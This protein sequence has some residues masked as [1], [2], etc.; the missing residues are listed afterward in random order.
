MKYGEGK[1]GNRQLR[2]EIVPFLEGREEE[3]MEKMRERPNL[4]RVRV[5][6]RSASLFAHAISSRSVRKKEE[7]LSRSREEEDRLLTSVFVCGLLHE[8]SHVRR[9]ETIRSESVL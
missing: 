1:E 8:I 9:R 2:G 6:A 7:Q 5:Y 4:L 3:G